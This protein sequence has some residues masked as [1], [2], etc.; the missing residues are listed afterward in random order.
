MKDPAWQTGKT[1][2]IFALI[3]TN[4]D[5]TNFSFILKWKLSLEFYR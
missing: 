3:F 4:I 1:R 2:I 5:Q